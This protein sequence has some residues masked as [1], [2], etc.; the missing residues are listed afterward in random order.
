LL[1][2]RK[3]AYWQLLL[4]LVLHIPIYLLFRCH[5][6]GPGFSFISSLKGI[7]A[8]N[9]I[10]LDSFIKLKMR[11]LALKF[12]SR[13]QVQPNPNDILINTWVS[14]LIVIV[15]VLGMENTSD[16]Q[17]GACRHATISISIVLLNNSLLH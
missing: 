16:M 4:F 3:L 1:F 9:L 15:Q 13:R 17:M 12:L 7:V 5:C 11:L 14:F 6:T 8:P 10:T 2:L